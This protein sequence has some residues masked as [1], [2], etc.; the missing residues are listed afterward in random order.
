MLSGGEV[1]FYRVELGMGVELRAS[2]GIYRRVTRDYQR[3]RKFTDFSFKR[4]EASL[5]DGLFLR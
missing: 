3:L 4:K 1:G 5:S 2:L